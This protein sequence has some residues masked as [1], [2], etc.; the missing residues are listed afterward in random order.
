M[1][2]PDRPRYYSFADSATITQ[3]VC[4]RILFVWATFWQAPCLVIVPSPFT[5]KYCCT[6]AASSYHIDKRP[7]ASA[8]AAVWVRNEINHSIVLCRVEV[9]VCLSYHVMRRSMTIELR[10]ACFCLCMMRLLPKSR[11]VVVDAVCAR[12]VVYRY[13]ED[14]QSKCVLAF[15]GVGVRLSESLRAFVAVALLEQTNLYPNNIVQSLFCTARLLRVHHTCTG[16]R[17][18]SEMRI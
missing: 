14:A 5:P 9:E 8:S 17:S 3:S 16:V 12:V 6:S 11:G 1:I 10:R 2:S 4:T 13:D 18:T 7:W 15:G